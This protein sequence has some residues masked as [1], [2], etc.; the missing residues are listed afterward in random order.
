ACRRRYGT[1]SSIA[2]AVA[3]AADRQDVLGLRRVGLELL[4]QVTHMDVDRPRIAEIGA[5]PQRLEQKAPAEH[6][7]GQ[8]GERSQQLELDVRERN[9]LPAQLDGA[10]SGVDHE[11]VRLDALAAGRAELA[12]PLRS[13]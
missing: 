1:G 2:K 6:P 5:A 10:A 11:T 9:R 8:R 3:H 12:R 13:A 4:A 7:A